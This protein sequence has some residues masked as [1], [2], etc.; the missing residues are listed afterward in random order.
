MEYYCYILFS[1]SLNRFYTGS[2]ELSVSE[3]LDRHLQKYYGNNKFTSKAVDWELYYK[4]PCETR[5]QAKE[6]ENHLKKMKSSIYLK[7]LVKYPEIAEKLKVRYR[8]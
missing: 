2:T 5:T 1:V 4:I 6:I 8:A 3:R 7:N